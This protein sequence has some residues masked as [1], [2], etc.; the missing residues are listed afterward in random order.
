MGSGEK[1]GPSCHPSV[2][3]HVWLHFESAPPIDH[4]SGNPPWHPRDHSKGTATQLVLPEWPCHLTDIH[5]WGLWQTKASHSSIGIYALY[6][7]IGVIQQNNRHYHVVSCQS[8][9]GFKNDS[10]L[11]GSML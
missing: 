7:M 1:V 4:L 6:L 8:T 10:A 9:L 2:S 3:V 5:A 11:S